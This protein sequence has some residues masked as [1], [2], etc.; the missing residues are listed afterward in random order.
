MGFLLADIRK[1]LEFGEAV[2]ATT[3]SAK[4]N[5]TTKPPF[6]WDELV[7]SPEFGLLPTDEKVRMQNVYFYEYLAPDTEDPQ[8]FVKL[9]QFKEAYAL[10]SGQGYLSS[11]A[12]SLL[13]GFV[14]DGIGRGISVIGEGWTWATHV[15]DNWATVV[16]DEVRH[17]T[18]TLP[19]Y[20]VNPVYCKAPIVIAANWAGCGLFYVIV[21]LLL[22]RLFVNPRIQKKTKSAEPTQA[23]SAVRSLDI[24]IPTM[25]IEEANKIADKVAEVMVAAEY[26]PGGYT[27]LSLVGASSRQE[28]ANALYIV[29]AKTFA[30]SSGKKED[31]EWFANWSKSSGG[32]LSQMLWMFPCVPDSELERIATMTKF[33]PEFMEEDK[34]LRQLIENDGTK[35]LETAESFIGFLKTLHATSPDYWTQVY[36]RIGLHWSDNASRKT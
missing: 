32:S 10:D 6:S 5:T 29:L 25:T 26:G 12:G 21:I 22:F 16:G 28:V 1:K 9:R 7:Q 31:L 14:E 24:R 33:S 17:M 11:L 30:E 35:T 19:A 18:Y 34:R 15:K 4:L 36:S 20:N 3:P 8:Y 23:G 13:R 27:P 2:T